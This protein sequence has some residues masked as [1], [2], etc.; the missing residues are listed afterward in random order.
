MGH[1][2]GLEPVQVPAWQVS[3][4]VQALPSVQLVPFCAAGLV[5]FPL[6]GSHTPATWHWS[7]GVQVLG[8]PPLQVPA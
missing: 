8:V 4:W 1:D 3:V 2:T 5:Q 6:V 7:D